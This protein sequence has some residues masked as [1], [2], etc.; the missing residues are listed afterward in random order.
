[1]GL[2]N[3]V[4]K[5]VSTTLFSPLFTVS[6]KT[7]FQLSVKIDAVLHL[8]RVSKGAKTRWPYWKTETTCSWKTSLTDQRTV[9]EPFV[10]SAN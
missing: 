5:L 6:L 10:G 2:S 8:G 1:M 4:R 9:P 7:P 3:G